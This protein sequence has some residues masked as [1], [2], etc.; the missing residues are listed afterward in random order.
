MCVYCWN[1]VYIHIDI[2][3]ATDILYY[4]MLYWYQYDLCFFVSEELRELRATQQ[5]ADEPAA[6]PSI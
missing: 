5:P 2:A 6:T 1:Y 3:Y 4:V